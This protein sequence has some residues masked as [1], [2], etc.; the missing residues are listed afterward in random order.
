MRV[1]VWRDGEGLNQRASQLSPRVTASDGPALNLLQL[2][3]QSHCTC[4]PVHRSV[5]AG[6]TMHHPCLTTVNPQVHRDSAPHH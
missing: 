4:Q 2:P 5:L 1:A 3:Q 6:R